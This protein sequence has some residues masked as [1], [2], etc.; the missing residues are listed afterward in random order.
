MFQL[1]GKF[2]AQNYGSVS[3]LVLS[4]RERDIED[5]LKTFFTKIACIQGEAIDADIKTHVRYLLANDSRLT[6]WAPEIKLE[7]ESALVQGAHGM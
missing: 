4:R 5:E 6:K 1:M 7:I 3:L 2:R